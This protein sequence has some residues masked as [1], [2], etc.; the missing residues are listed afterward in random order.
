MFVGKKLHFFHAQI[1]KLRY[2]DTKLLAAGASTTEAAVQLYLS[3]YT[4]RD[5]I[6]T[7]M[8]R[9]DAKNRTEVAV[10]AIRMGIIEWKYGNKRINRKYLDS[11]DVL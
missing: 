5:Y 4:V 8:R 11:L 7:I 10:K 6:S 3:E 9:L 2:K 1:S